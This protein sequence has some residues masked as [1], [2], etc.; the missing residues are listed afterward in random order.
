[1]AKSKVSDV[2]MLEKEN[3]GKAGRNSF[4]INRKWGD[5]L[6]KQNKVISWREVELGDL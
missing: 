2:P 3:S 6:L 1:M 5:V 4:K